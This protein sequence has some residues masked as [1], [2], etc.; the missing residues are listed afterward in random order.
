VK[1]LGALHPVRP[2]TARAQFPLPIPICFNC[3]WL[4]FEHSACSVLLCTPILPTG[5]VVFQAC[6]VPTV[7]Q[8]FLLIPLSYNAAVCAAALL[9]YACRTEPLAGL[10]SH[11]VLR[12]DIACCVPYRWFHPRSSGRFCRGLDEC[13]YAEEHAGST[14]SAS[15]SRWFLPAPYNTSASSSSLRLRLHMYARTDGQG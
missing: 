11:R 1:Y 4:S 10:L 2:S 8:P 12:R 3:T 5:H 9:Q 13:L 6:C 14:P 7:G 15:V